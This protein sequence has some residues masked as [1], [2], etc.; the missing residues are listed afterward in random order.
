MTFCRILPSHNNICM[1][2]SKVGFPAT[3]T[4]SGIWPPCVLDF[5]MMRSIRLSLVIELLIYVLSSLSYPTART[6]AAA[7]V[8]T[9]MYI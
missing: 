1:P 7:V 6:S 9:S 4:F 3:A 8:K 5:W 2:I